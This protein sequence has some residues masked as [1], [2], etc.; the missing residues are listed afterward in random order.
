MADRH[1][2]TLGDFGTSS[3]LE[4]QRLIFHFSAHVFYK[5][6]GTTTMHT[7]QKLEESAQEK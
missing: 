5:F 4:L 2:R 1:P 6:P 3:V 7:T